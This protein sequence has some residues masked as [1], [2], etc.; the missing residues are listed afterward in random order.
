MSTVSG[1][2]ALPP[3]YERDHS[4]RLWQGSSSQIGRLAARADRWMDWHF[5]SVTGHTTHHIY[6]VG[7]PRGAW[8]ADSPAD[9]AGEIDARRGH[10]TAVGIYAYALPGGLILNP[11]T[12][13][14]PYIRATGREPRPQSVTITA[15]TTVQLTFLRSRPLGPRAR[16]A[17]TVTFLRHPLRPR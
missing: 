14:G 11:V 12:H 10:V 1:Q 16:L 9:L 8:G 17:M 7:T 5:R 15:P 4:W 3:L 2:P 6:S 13:P